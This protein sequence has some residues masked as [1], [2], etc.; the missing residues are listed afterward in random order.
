MKKPSKFCRLRAAIRTLITY[1]CQHAASLKAIEK[2]YTR[3]LSDGGTGDPCKVILSIRKC[4]QLYEV[5]RGYF[6]HNE[7]KAD[8]KWLATYGW[9]SNGHLIAIGRC[10]YVIFDAQRKLVVVEN[11]PD[12]GPD[13]VEIYHEA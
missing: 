9:H 11:I 5:T 1:G 13:T 4:G 10:T 12:K 2:T 8:E 7:F 3:C 6:V